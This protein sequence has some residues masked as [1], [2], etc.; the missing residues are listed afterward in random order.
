MPHADLSVSAIYE[1]LCPQSKKKK[2]IAETFE[3]YNYDS[4]PS[5]EI[6]ECYLAREIQ[7]VLDS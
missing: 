1:I 7:N 6:F 2:N 3:K 5:M 4:N